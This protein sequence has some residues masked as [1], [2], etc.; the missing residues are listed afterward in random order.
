MPAPATPSLPRDGESI[1]ALAARSMFHLFSSVSQGMFLVDRTGRIVWLNE[2][3]K[4]FLP[5]L[6]FSS[7]EDVVGHMVEDVVPNTQM[8]RVLETGEPILVDLLT[9]RAGTFVV[10]RIPLRDDESGELIGAIGIVLFDH[11]ETTLQPLIS[12]FARLQRDLDDARRELAT[13]RRTK[14]TL[15]SFVGASPAAVEVKRHARRAALSSSPVLL[16]GET[17]TGKELLAHAIHAASQRAGGPLVSVNIAAVPDTLLEAEFFGVAPGAYTG[18]ERK[19]R[20]GKFKLADGGT[21]FLD[22]IGDMPLGLQPKLLRALQEGEIEPLGS[23]KVVPFDARVIAATSRDLAALVREG[24]F[25]EDLYYRLNVLPVRVPPLRERRS[26]IPSLVEVL[27]EEIAARGGAAPP[28]LAPEAMAL[29][30]AQRWR[31]NIRELRNVLEQAAMR[32]DTQRIEAAHVDA[33]LREAGIR[34]IVAP[35]ATRPAPA[36]APARALRPLA[37][38]VGELERQ[39]IGAA[40]A[41]TGGNKLATA[42]LLGISRAKLYERLATMPEFQSVP[43]NRTARSVSYPDNPSEC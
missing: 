3:Y 28:E 33:V 22:E 12:K 23:N 2:G 25:R 18:A 10:S 30:S 15:A 24:K 34:D 1:L 4:R 38:Q 8:R 5:A 35:I 6:G 21:L 43:K 26:D 19:G 37:Q 14:Y 27:A 11:P 40:L 36:G 41:A 32:T 31:G 17:G 29:L 39:A 42:K 13:Q 20:V 9:N 7:S 16:L